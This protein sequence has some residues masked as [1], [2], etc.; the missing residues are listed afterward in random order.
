MYYSR[1]FC[2]FFL[3]FVINRCVELLNDY[4][5]NDVKRRNEFL[6]LENK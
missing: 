1:N 6:H 5:T 3:I 4:L 2:S